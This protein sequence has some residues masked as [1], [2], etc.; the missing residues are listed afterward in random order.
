[1]FP[2][3]DGNSDTLNNEKDSLMLDLDS[4]SSGSELSAQMFN[5]GKIIIHL[6]QCGMMKLKLVEGRTMN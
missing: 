3:D 2:C 4:V 1:V 5:D 6:C